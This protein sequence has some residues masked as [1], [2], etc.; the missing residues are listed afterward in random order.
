MT[1][2]WSIPMTFLRATVISPNANRLE[3]PRRR[4]PV[5]S[6]PDGRSSH[7]QIGGKCGISFRE[8]LSRRAS[9]SA[10]LLDIGGEDRALLAGHLGDVARRHCAGPSGD[11]PDQA[12][13]AMDVL[14]RIEQDALRRG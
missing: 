12:D 2:A 4:P 10:R 5:L 9:A 13:V 11:A 8:T 1:T 3:P 7:F 6:T 14:G